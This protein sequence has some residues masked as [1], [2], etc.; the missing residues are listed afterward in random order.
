LPDRVLAPQ[1]TFFLAYEL[2][3][4]DQK[5]L[6]DDEFLFA[7]REQINSWVGSEKLKVFSFQIF[8]KYV[9]Y[10]LSNLGLFWVIVLAK[11]GR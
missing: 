10:I 9:A 2:G 1:V 8:A 5:F 11:Y 4:T 7:V 6:V 3:Q